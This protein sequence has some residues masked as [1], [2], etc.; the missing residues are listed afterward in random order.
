MKLLV[1]TDILAEHLM[2]ETG[3]ESVLEKA[4]SSFICFTTVQN[5]SEIYYAVGDQRE[6]ADLL[7]RSMK[8]LG[9]HYR[10][11]ADVPEFS[12]NT[13]SLRDAL[14][15]SVAKNNKLNILTNK[16]EKYQNSGLKIIHPKNL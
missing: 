7:L 13:E 16:I 5:V 3:G 9:I 8:I 6:E 1:E 15:C 2:N 4:M 10:Y 11:S 12:D 14:I